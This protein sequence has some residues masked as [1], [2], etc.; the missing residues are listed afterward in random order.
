LP[1]FEIKTIHEALSS[2]TGL[3]VGQFRECFGGVPQFDEEPIVEEQPPM[4][5]RVEAPSEGRDYG[6]DADL[7][8]F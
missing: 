7:G 3:T 6:D 2:G 5:D 1:T 8:G 4:D